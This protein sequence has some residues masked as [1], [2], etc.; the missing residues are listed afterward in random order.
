MGRA[1]QPSLVHLVSAY[2]T[3]A[4]TAKLTI[5]A[6]WPGREMPIGTGATV[7]TGSALAFNPKLLLQPG[8]RVKFYFE[9]ATAGDIVTVGVEGH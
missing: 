4:T 1:V 3:F 9:N 8:Q 5:Y 2:G 6:G 7:Q